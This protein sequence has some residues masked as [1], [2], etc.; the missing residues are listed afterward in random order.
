MHSI[1]NIPHLTPKCYALAAKATTMRLLLAQAADHTSTGM[2]AA[3][4]PPPHP[5][6]HISQP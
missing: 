5:F 2:L 1:P 6:C 4:Q 3:Q